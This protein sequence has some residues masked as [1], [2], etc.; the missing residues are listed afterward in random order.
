MVIVSVL[1]VSW[2]HVIIAAGLLMDADTTHWSSPF[3]SFMEK[4]AE[5]TIQSIL[6]QLN[7]VMA[8][9]KAASFSEAIKV[10]QLNSHTYRVSLN[11]AFC[12]GASTKSL[13]F[14]PLA[15]SRSASL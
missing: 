11:N 8:S 5:P 3:L 7:L 15:S 6:S 4:T 12:T 13:P 2:S 1:T 9:G 10:E 14:R